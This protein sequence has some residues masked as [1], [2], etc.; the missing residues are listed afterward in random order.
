MRIADAREPRLADR[1]GDDAGEFSRNAARRRPLHRRPGDER[2]LARRP[3]RFSR[4]LFQPHRNLLSRHRQLIEPPRRADD[5]GL[6]SFIRVG[7]QPRHQDLRS[8]T[9]RV[10]AS[11]RK[12][13]RWMVGHGGKAQAACAPTFGFHSLAL[14]A[15]KQALVS[16]AVSQRLAGPLLFGRPDPPGARHSSPAAREEL[17]KDLRLRAPH[18]PTQH[19]LR[20]KPDIAAIEV[21]LA[22]QFFSSATTSREKLRRFNPTRLSPTTSSRSA[23]IR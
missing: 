13:H 9:G 18:T 7:L 15:T 3:A 6:P 17:Q 14:A 5:R 20:P 11:E 4:E 10:A 8:D 1:T 2:T 21:D 19:L 16:I 23:A 22:E 12:L